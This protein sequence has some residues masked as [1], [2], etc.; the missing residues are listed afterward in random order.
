[1]AP[2]RLVE[3]RIQDQRHAQQAPGFYHPLP[4]PSPLPLPL[5]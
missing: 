1:M 5:P 4:Q 2:A 3:Q